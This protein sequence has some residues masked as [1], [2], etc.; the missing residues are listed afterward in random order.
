MKRKI[1]IVDDEQSIADLVEVYLSN[2]GMEVLKCYNGQDALDCI[3]KEDLSLAVLD[4]ML[5]DIDGYKLCQEI[6][7]EHFLSCH[8]ADCPDRG[9]RQDPGTYH[10]RGRLHYQA[11]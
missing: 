1:L 2:E 6:R 11:F 10:R 7:K 3:K 9:H 4:V 5:P 8:H